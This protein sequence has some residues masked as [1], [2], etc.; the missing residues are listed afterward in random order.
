MRTAIHKTKQ[1]NNNNIINN[2]WKY[3]PLLNVMI[4][5]LATIGLGGVTGRFRIFQ[6]K[7]F[8]PLAVRFVFFVALPCLVIKVSNRVLNHSW[9]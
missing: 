9:S 6:A 5:I 4:Q 2:M 1:S 8:V 7:E 3:T